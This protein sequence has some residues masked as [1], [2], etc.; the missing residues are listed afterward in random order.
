MAFFLN[1]EW[2]WAFFINFII[3]L[4][5]HKLPFLTS[6][7]WFHAGI[8]GTILLGCIG[9]NAWL[10]VAFYLLLGTVVTK[11]GFSFKKAKGI[12][13][14]RGGRRGPENVWGSAATGAFLALIYKL[15]NGSGEYLIFIGFA[16]SFSAKL[17]DTFGS[18][19]GK[20][21]GRRT[22]LISTLNPVPAGTDGAIS[23]EGTVAS[24]VGSSLMGLIM[25]YLYFLPSLISLFIVIFSAF[26]ATLMESFFGAFF[27]HRIK[28]MSN[29]L[30]NFI[31][32][33]FASILSM[34]VG[35]AFL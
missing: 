25:Y 7:G 28:W 29:E 26:I 13:E 35:L 23:L 3:I 11:I 10:A 14:G 12:A 34:S 5:A 1:S 2:F 18:E 30:V 8:L 15:L 31:Q 20:R 9:W 27:Q 6:E 19:I 22:Y 16:S 21:W 24:F 17:A 32:T 33:I 4:I